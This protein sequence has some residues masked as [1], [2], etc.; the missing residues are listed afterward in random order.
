MFPTPYWT[1]WLAKLYPAAS[2]TDQSFASVILEPAP[3]MMLP[4]VFKL[5]P[6][7]SVNWP[8]VRLPAVPLKFNVAPAAM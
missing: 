5:S 6:A 3:K 7:S 4:S 8:L 1:A 2:V